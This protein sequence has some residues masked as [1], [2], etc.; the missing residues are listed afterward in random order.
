M[1]FIWMDVEAPAEKG[2][3]HTAPGKSTSDTETINIILRL[4]RSPL[5]AGTHMWGTPWGLLSIPT[6]RRAV[7]AQILVN[8]VT[9]FSSLLRSLCLPPIPFLVHTL[10]LTL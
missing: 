6:P 2:E 4:Y 8:T 9:P 7:S 3:E 10:S 1:T 5:E